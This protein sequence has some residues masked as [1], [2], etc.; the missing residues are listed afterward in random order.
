MGDADRA[1]A[2]STDTQAPD[3]EALTS[4][5]AGLD[6]DQLA[7]LRELEED[8]GRSVV[9]QLITIYL[10]GAADYV[11]N[12]RAAVGRGDIAET[13]RLAHGFK[14][15]SATVGAASVARACAA[16]EEAAIGG[17]ATDLP[18]KMAYVE[19]ELRRTRPVLDAERDRPLI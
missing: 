3:T 12:L 9:A 11:D 15:S 19:L 7:S 10:D 2:S 8:S 14:G 17:A 1:P 4:T 18:G 16:L 5:A 13:G 6:A